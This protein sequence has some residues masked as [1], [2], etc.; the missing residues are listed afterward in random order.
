MAGPYYVRSTDGNDGDSGLTWALAKATIAGA[1]AIAAAGETIYVSQVHAETAAA[2][3]TLT[4]A[5]TAAAPI[6]I[7][8]GNDAAEPPTALATTATV[9]TTGN[10]DITIAGVAYIYG[11]TFQSGATASGASQIRLSG[12]N[13]I[14]TLDSCTLKVA[15]TQ[16]ANSSGID[17][18]NGAVQNRVVLI[19]VA[20]VF[21]AA[22]QTIYN[23]GTCDMVGGSIGA[24]GTAPTIAITG[25]NNYI[26]GLRLRGVDLSALGSGKSLVRVAQGAGNVSIENCKLG[27]S[28]AL[29][30]GTP[31]GAQ[32]IRIALD[33]SDSADTQ[34]R[35]QRHSYEGDVYSETTI[36]RSS[37]ASDGT[38]PLSW[39]MVSSASRVLFDPLYS[40]EIIFWN[41][42]TGASKTVTVE[43][44]HD[45]VTALTD[46]EVW[47]EVEALTTSG[48][49]LSTFTSDRVADI[50]ATAAAQASSSVAWTTTGITNVN[51][52][53]LEVTFTPAGIGWYRCRVALA[54]ASY[55]IY[56]DPFLSGFSTSGKQYLNPGG[57]Y[58]NEYAAAVSAPMLSGLVVA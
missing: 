23:N 2:A 15:T 58:V 9:T 30:T 57:A 17:T 33:N 11:I 39:K 7:L 21:S 19:N 43:I 35:M 27:A 31:I 4:S 51:K 26:S 16:D 18:A 48:F 22:G 42:T 49:P 24:T 41:D 52:Q 53:K 10:N 36:V 56:V 37:G 3:K 25:A 28:V 12:A 14:L 44:V 40:P 29:K 38:T 13:H 1:L 50:L 6:R 54:K 5:G 8:C 46:A 32:G 47:A 20:I 45:S 34:Y 55:T